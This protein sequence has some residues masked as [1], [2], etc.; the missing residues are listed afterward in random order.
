MNDRQ[1]NDFYKKD[2]LHD[3]ETTLA[4]MP[5]NT[6]QDVLDRMQA[7]IDKIQQDYD[8]WKTKRIA[9]IV[10]QFGGIPTDYLCVDI[11]DAE[12]QDALHARY[13]TYD[14][15][16][17]TYDTLPPVDVNGSQ[18]IVYQGWV[19]GNHRLITD[20]TTDFSGLSLTDPLYFKLVLVQDGPTQAISVQLLTRQEDEEFSDLPVNLVYCYTACEGRVNTDNSIT[21]GA[22]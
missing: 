16:A 6:H 2:Q 13:I 9:S 18:V 22:F 20:D 3:L 11:P 10:N 1:G 4:N 7:A 19:K 5:G 8:A 21:I 12:I 14:G 15:N 17:F